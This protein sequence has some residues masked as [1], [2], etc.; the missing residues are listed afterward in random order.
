MIKVNIGDYITFNHEEY[1]DGYVL[2]ILD[3]K[4]IDVVVYEHDSYYNYTH[5]IIPITS[6]T[7]ATI[8]KPITFD[9]VQMNKFIVSL[10]YPV[11]ED[12]K[13]IERLC[14]FERS[15]PDTN[16]F[17]CALEDDKGECKI[18]AKVCNSCT[19]GNKCNHCTSKDCDGCRHQ[20]FMKKLKELY[21]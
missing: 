3:G 20:D 12:F 16:K 6:V 1:S 4:D 15:L 21:N 5:T 17:K 11:H 2:N 19:F 18:G 13:R 8:R 7:S 9:A 10:T 14:E